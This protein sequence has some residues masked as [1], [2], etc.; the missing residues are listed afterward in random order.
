MKKI[1]VKFTDFYDGFE[2]KKFDIY[3]I[4]SKR[5]EVIISEEPEYLIFSVWGYD[6][7][8]YNCIKIFY[9]GENL[10]PDF[11]LCDYAI[12]FDYITFQDRYFRLPLFYTDQYKKDF[13]LMMKKHLFNPNDVMKEKT[14]F[15]SFVYSNGDADA[16]REMLFREISRYKKVNSGGRFEN[17]IDGPVA[18]KLEFQRKHKFAIASENSSHP[19]YATEK[20]VQAYAART[21]PI[22]WGDTCIEK[23]FNPRSMINAN[24]FD[25]I[26]KLVEFIKYVDED[27]N[28]YIKMLSESA[29]LDDSWSRDSIYGEYEKF[30][31]SII[32][33]P[34]EKA[35][36]Y[37]RHFWGEIYHKRLRMYKKGYD[38]NLIMCIKDLFTKIYNKFYYHFRKLKHL[39]RPTTVFHK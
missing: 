22:Y 36:R 13:E 35:I 10:C 31:Y 24:K 9:T 29:L 16:M 2:Y 32:E 28:A 17:N 37:N 19:G 21:V 20:L 1:K 30:I 3:K 11:N 6:N 7:L 12:G 5:Y 15:C 34:L 18:D 39:D 8:N 26:D 38:T 25:S 33:Q 27:E 14:E 23:M 4:L